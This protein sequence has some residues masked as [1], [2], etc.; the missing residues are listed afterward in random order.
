MCRIPTA[1]GV[2]VHVATIGP[3]R[4]PAR[5]A[6]ARVP[7][8][9]VLLAPPAR[10][11]R[12]RGLP[13]PRAGHARLRREQPARGDRGVRQRRAAR[14]RPRADRP[15]DAA[16]RS[17]DRAR[18]GREPRVALRARRARTRRVRGGAE[19]AGRLPRAPAAPAPR[20]CAEHLG[21]DFY[22]VWFQEPGVADA[23]LAAD[24]RRTLATTKV[25]TEAWAESDDDPPTPRFMS[26]DEFQVYVDTYTETGFTGGLNYYRNIDR[27]WETARRTSGARS[28]C[29]RCS[30]RAPATRS[31]TSCRRRR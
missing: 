27:N 31:G 9:V 7:G 2:E 21:E 19:R 26:E 6:A 14:G 1:P 17:G 24:P 30:S 25:W 13:R 12:R 8:A 28:T 10:A 4:R 3:G 23:V 18:L 22:I 29:R 11:A 5:P 15:C 16:A 20:S